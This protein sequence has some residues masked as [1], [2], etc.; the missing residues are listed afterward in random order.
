MIPATPLRRILVAAIALIGLGVLGGGA[1]GQ[2]VSAVAGTPVGGA[3]AAGQSAADQTDLDAMN[4]IVAKVQDSLVLYAALAED[5]QPLER[6]WQEEFAFELMRWRAAYQDALALAPVPV[7]AEN[8]GRYL[9]APGLLAETSDSVNAAV[10]N[11]DLA[12]QMWAGARM[13][14]ATRLFDQA[15]SLMEGWPASNASC[16]QRAHPPGQRPSQVWREPPGTLPSPHRPLIAQAQARS[17]SWW[18]SV[19][20]W[21][22][23]ISPRASPR[24]NSPRRTRV[25]ERATS[26]RSPEATFARVDDLLIAM[27]G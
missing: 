13:L 7:C 25:K 1:L 11:G 12:G 10:N 18:R 9:E 27:P 26:R 19:R 5:P 8:H 22:W 23:T 20:M 17:A 21:V 16:N 24:S 6:D 3:T 14:Q 2:V 15:T 4:P